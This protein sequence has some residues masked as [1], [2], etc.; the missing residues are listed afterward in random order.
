MKNV[1]ERG[2]VFV[3]HF[4]SR[5]GME[6]AS[7]PRVALVFH[8]DVLGRQVRIEGT[9][10]TVS[11]K[12]SDDLFATRPREN[13]LSSAASPQSTVITLEVLDR[14]FEKLHSEYDGKNVPRPVSWGGYRI[15]PDR[16]EFWQHRFARLNDR[17][18]YIRGGNPVRPQWKK[19]RLAP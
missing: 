9:A 16:M 8:W 1:D 13:Q 18:V 3:T 19:L 17:I 4:S 7:N 5:K 11:E 15:R 12:E 14:R 2:F 10:E 6:I